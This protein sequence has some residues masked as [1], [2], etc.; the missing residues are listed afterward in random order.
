MKLYSFP[1]NVPLSSFSMSWREQTRKE[2]KKKWFTYS[3]SCS[4]WYP[5]DPP[6]HAGKG[7]DK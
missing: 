1:L 4:L 2:E 3:C 7:E 5:T 6:E